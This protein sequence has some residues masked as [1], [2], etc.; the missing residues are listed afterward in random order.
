[1]ITLALS[2]SCVVICWETVLGRKGRNFLINVIW[3]KGVLRMLLWFSLLEVF[4]SCWV[5]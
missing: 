3:D 1:M 4:V 5:G 2:L